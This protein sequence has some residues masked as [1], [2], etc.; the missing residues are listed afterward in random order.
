[1]IQIENTLR[2]RFNNANDEA[3]KYN[4]S[5]DAE[6]NTEAQ[7]VR[8]YSGSVRKEEENIATFSKHDESLNVVYYDLTAQ[9]EANEAIN[10][11]VAEVVEKAKGIN[12]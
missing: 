6:I 12:F 11:F 5:A 9:A 1:M 4:I 3:K 2:V 10:A 7:I 8:I